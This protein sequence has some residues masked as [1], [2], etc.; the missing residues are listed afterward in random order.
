MEHNFFQQA[1]AYAM[2]QGVF[3]G[4]WWV[5]GFAGFVGCFSL[6]I[7]AL[8][9]LFIFF[10]TPFLGG[11]FSYRFKASTDAPYSY[12]QLYVH[13][14][15]LYFYASIWLAVAV[16]VYFA[17]IDHGFLFQSYLDYLHSPEVEAQLSTPAMQEELSRMTGGKDIDTLVAE[18]AS[19]SPA[20]Y[21]ANSVATNIFFGLI[22]SMPTALVV[23]CIRTTYKKI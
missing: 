6:P 4:I 3:F 8:P 2:R 1:N 12:G 5:L 11:V 19:I 18:L 13:S 9:A 22:L 20:T 14:A 10:S 17:F 21:A 7:V 16:Y 23:R 15:L